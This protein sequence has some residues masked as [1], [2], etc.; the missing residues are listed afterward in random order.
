VTPLA[1]SLKDAAATLGVSPSHFQRHIRHEL[2]PPVFVGK[3]V[4]WKHV[5]LARWLEKQ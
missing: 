2:P 4:V 3:R 5:D 1:Y